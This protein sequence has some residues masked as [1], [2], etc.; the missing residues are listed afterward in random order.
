MQKFLK[1]FKMKK[2][3]FLCLLFCIG[4]KSYCQ[5]Q[6]ITICSEKNGCQYAKVSLTKAQIDILLA[7]PNFLAKEKGVVL[8]S[9]VN[10]SPSIEKMTVQQL[11]QKFGGKG[12][13]KEIKNFDLRK[14]LLDKNCL[15]CPN[16][17]KR[18]SFEITT[19]GQTMKGFYYHNLNNKESFMPDESYKE[20]YKDMEI[21]NM[22]HNSFILDN[23]F[24]SYTINPEGNK[25]KSIVTSGS[26]DQYI[27]S[28]ENIQRIKNTIKKTG[29]KKPFIATTRFQYQYE[30]Q[31]GEGNKIMMWITPAPNT[32][33]RKGQIVPSGF[34]NLGYLEIDGEAHFISEISGNNYLIK[35]THI[36]VGSYSFT[37]VG[38]KTY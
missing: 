22:T 20:L 31:D 29:N 18:I 36:E 27:N 10:C 12:V 3:Y 9:L 37:P 26:T 19:D 1:M 7:K 5:D 24:I 15:G 17:T 13:S 34:Y 6:V 35:V 28:D 23:K 8:L 30:T 38:Y 14:Y 21:S 4:L 16:T 25:F 2:F 32:C 11:H 33:F